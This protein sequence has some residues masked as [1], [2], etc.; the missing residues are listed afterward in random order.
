MRNLYARVESGTFS[1]VEREMKGSLWRGALRTSVWTDQNWNGG[2]E[3]TW[4]RV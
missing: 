1:P 3:S 2:E 4:A